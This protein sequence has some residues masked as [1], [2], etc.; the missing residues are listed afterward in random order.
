[1]WNIYNLF[2][3]KKITQKVIF[4]K[5]EWHIYIVLAADDQYINF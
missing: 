1:M 2:L 5:K 4:K 3:T